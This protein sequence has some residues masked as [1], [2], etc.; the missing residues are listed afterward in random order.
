MSLASSAGPSPPITT[1]RLIADYG[2]Q[3]V[4]SAILMAIGAAATAGSVWI[5][6]PVLTW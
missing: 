4:L 6:K 3:H 1:R 2:R 5:L